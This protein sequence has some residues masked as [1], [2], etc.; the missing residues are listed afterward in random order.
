[1]GQPDTALV[2]SGGEPV[3]EPRL[4]AVQILAFD[5]GPGQL[6]IAL[7]FKFRIDR[8]LGCRDPDIAL[9][10]TL[11]HEPFDDPIKAQAAVEVL[12]DQPFELGNRFRREKGVE[13]EHDHP[14]Q[15]LHVDHVLEIHYAP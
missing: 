8:G 15:Q 2:P 7:D 11:G 6:V 14:F 5:P 13:L 3:N 4:S 1:M 9:V 12:R 10:S